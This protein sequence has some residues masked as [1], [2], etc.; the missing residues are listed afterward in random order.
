MSKQIRIL[1]EYPAILTKDKEWA[2][3]YKPRIEPGAIVILPEDAV[4]VLPPEV[5]SIDTTGID[6]ESLDSASTISVTN[7]Q[8]EAKQGKQS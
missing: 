2:N 4:L 8:G 6:L 3:R 7:P 5:M 1:T